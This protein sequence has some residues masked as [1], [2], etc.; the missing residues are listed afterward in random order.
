MPEIRVSP[1]AHAVFV[2][3]RERIRL[4]Q[5]ERDALLE[6]V[7]VYRDALAAQQTRDQLAAIINRAEMRP[8]I[9]ESK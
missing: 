8:L 2:R 1:E 5:M 9:Q 4:L 6:I 3:Q 7:A